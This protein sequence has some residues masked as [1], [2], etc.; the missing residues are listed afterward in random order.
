MARSHRCTSCCDSCRSPQERPGLGTPT[1][2]VSDCPHFADLETEASGPFV[3]QSR[4]PVRREKG[5]SAALL[6]LQLFP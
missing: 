4:S 1:G 6:A 5:L 2:Q 3:A